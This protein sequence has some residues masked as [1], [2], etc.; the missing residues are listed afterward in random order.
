[1]KLDLKKFNP[2]VTELEALRMGAKEIV[3]TD[4]QD[5]KQLSAVSTMRKELK[6]VRVSLS[7]TGKELRKEATQF[8]KAVIAK[9]KEL[10]A[11][12]EPEEIR[13][14]AIEDEAKELVLMEKR[15]ADLPK[16][17]KQ[18]AE[19]GDGLEVED[20]ILLAMTDLVY[21]TYFNRRVYEKNEADKLKVEQEKQKLEK[22]KQELREAE[23]ATAR[24]IKE[25]EDANKE[26]SPLEPAIANF[27]PTEKQLPP[28]GASQ[29]KA[30]GIKYK[31]WNYFEKDIHNKAI[32]K[33][34]KLIEDEDANY[35]TWFKDFTN[36]IKKLLIR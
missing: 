18:L 32:K 14:Q 25:R 5:K 3:V 10:I 20:K 15:K 6:E 22:E 13:L 24:E 27:P 36:A 21:G 28:M 30:H 17:K 1:M 11:I 23:E 26:E 12:I 19:I 9:E 34:L 7:K 31:Y 33:C 35:I 16:W 8:S 4:L 29:W 2:T